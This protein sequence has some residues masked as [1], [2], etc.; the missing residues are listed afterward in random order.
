MS[1]TKGPWAV[2]GR[3]VR[4]VDGSEDQIAEVSI[5]TKEY[6]A[7]G[8]ANARLI[9]A[10]PDLLEALQRVVGNAEQSVFED[11][12]SSNCPS[13]D[14]EQVHQQWIASAEY[15]D[16]CIDWLDERAAIS[17]ALGK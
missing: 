1:Y 7:E 14:S 15:E 13:G 3:I 16:F 12:L 10:A 4:D 8:I 5:N 17:K 9:S 2:Y 6:D 11:W